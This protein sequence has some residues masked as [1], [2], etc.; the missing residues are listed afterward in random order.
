MAALVISVEVSAVLVLLSRFVFCFVLTLM[1]P[2]VYF[3]V[4]VNMTA[5]GAV[6][7]PFDCFLVNRGLKTLPVR[8]KAHMANGFAVARWLE[9]NPRVTRV[10]HPGQWQSVHPIVPI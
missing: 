10:V 3:S 8:M 4:C 6:P 9:S 7:S 1:V 5:I 2:H